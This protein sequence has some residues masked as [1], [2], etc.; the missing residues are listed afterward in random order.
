MLL[1]LVSVALF[2][3]APAL[4]A[5][6]GR[7]EELVAAYGA[8]EEDR[9]AAALL[10]ESLLAQAP[11]EEPLRLWEA[12]GATEG[13]ERAS[14]A[15]AL[16]EALFPGGDPARWEEVG[17]FWNPREIPLSLAALDAVYE[18]VLALDDLPDGGA[19]FLASTLLRRLLRSPGARIHAFLTAPAEYGQ[20]TSTLPALGPAWP[21][22][23]I[24]GRLPFARPVRGSVGQDRALREGF[25]FLDGCG[26][27]SSGLGTY[28]WDRREGKLFRVRD[29][30]PR[31]WLDD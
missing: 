2:G 12:L 19:S 13:R 25:T 9:R 4:S 8:R 28:A 14:R 31:W 30:R 3:T 27:P 11:R 26:R 16:V 22:G 20:L 1:L 21:Q 29:G 15:L 18:A 7:W 24:E 23:R 6:A 17:G 5:G 10:R